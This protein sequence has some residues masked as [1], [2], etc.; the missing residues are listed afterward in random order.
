NWASNTLFV[1]NGLDKDGEPINGTPGGKNSVS[2]EETIILS[3]RL[4]QLYGEFNEITIPTYGGTYVAQG[5]LTIPQEKT[6]KIVPGVTLAF[7]TGKQLLVRG[8]LLAQGEEESPILFTRAES[9]AWNGIRFFETSSNNSEISHA[10]VE[11]GLYKPD[12]SQLGAERMFNIGIEGSSPTIR[13]V[14][15]TSG[16]TWR[17]AIFLYNSSSL[18]ENVEIRGANYSSSSTAGIFAIEGSPTIKNSTFYNNTIGIYVDGPL[19]SSTITENTFEK[20]LYPVYLNRSYATVLEN[21][22]LDHT[23]HAIAVTGSIKDS[24]AVWESDNLPFLIISNFGVW[25]GATLSIAPGSTVLFA[26][27]SP[28]PILL[29]VYG[30]LKAEGTEENL[31]LFSDYSSWSGG[32]AKSWRYIQFYPSSTGSV[33][34]HAVIQNGGAIITGN[35]SYGLLYVQKSELELLNVTLKNGKRYEMVI[36]SVAENA[37]FGSNVLI[38]HNENNSYE[39]INVI[40]ETCPVFTSLEIQGGSIFAQNSLCQ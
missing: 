30:T 27:P 9:S 14:S 37:V 10:V 24:A 13:N 40:G 17:G 12:F 20:G 35:A 29:G 7:N 15:F 21:E 8:T 23:Y 4:T 36:E 3:E 34:S 28:H 5:S 31:I 38:M 25:E 11:G 6:L 19:A 16:S 18:I 39:A 33:I 26:N 1:R 32:S 22:V 2:Y